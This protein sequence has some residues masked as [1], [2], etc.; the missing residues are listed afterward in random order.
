MCPSSVSGGS[1]IGSIGGS[2]SD[3]GGVL[4][5]AAFAIRDADDFDTFADLADLAA[6]H[7]AHAPSGRFRQRR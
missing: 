2:D 5:A 4:D 7:S 6:T 3:A 1:P